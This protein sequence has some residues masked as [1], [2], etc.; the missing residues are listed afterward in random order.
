MDAIDCAMVHVLVTGGAGFVGNVIVE[1]LAAAEDTTVTLTYH[2]KEPAASVVAL[3]NVDAVQLDLA[4]EAGTLQ[5]QLA[6]AVKDKVDVLVLCAAWARQAAVQKEP[7]LGMRVNCDSG[8]TLAKALPDAH[9]VFI[10]SDMVFDGSIPLGTAYEEDSAQMCPLTAYGETKAEAERQLRTIAAGRLSVLRLAL[11]YGP[12]SPLFR[13][14]DGVLRAED[15]T[16]GMFTDEFRSAVH[17]QDVADA[18]RV[19]VERPD[20]RAQAHLVHVGGPESLSRY[21]LA[22]RIAAQYLGIAEPAMHAC[23]AADIDL[24]VPSVPNTAL[25]IDRLRTVLGIEPRALRPV[26]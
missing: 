20:V 1:T 13:W 17:V 7:E 6:A 2:E 19:L 24:G 21:E 23:R 25:A 26:Q 3:P 9:V 15:K 16:T 10:S 8:V 4:A 5:E 12:S 14:L 11:V 18:V 22:R